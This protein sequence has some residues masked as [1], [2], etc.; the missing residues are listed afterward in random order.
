MPALPREVQATSPF[1]AK[2]SVLGARGLAAI[3]GEQVLQSPEQCLIQTS[4]FTDGSGHVAAENLACLFP[5]GELR[6]ALGPLD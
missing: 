2:L 6:F 4:L 5:R 1:L 3:S